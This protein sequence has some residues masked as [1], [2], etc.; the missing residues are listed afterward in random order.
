M[1]QTMAFRSAARRS[2]TARLI[3]RAGV[4]ALAAV[5]LFFAAHQAGQ[6]SERAPVRSLLESRQAGVVMQAWDLSCGAAALATLLRHEHGDAVS[7]QEV[8]KGLI[9]RDEYIADPDRLKRQLGFSLL[10]LKRYV[11][12]RGY[13]GVGY[14]DL[15][16]DDIVRLAPILVTIASNG[17]NHFVVFR[18]IRGNRVLLADP[19]WGNRTML[20]GQ[21]EDAWLSHPNLGKVGFIIA[22]RDGTRPPNRLDISLAEFP[23]FK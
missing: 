20:I 23:M 3:H 6:A 14:K 9:K 7:E 13:R 11:D 18:G 19:A 1:T 16:F 21:F 8:A 4:A 15:K 17:Y 22:N 2:G 10:D 12:D 5:A